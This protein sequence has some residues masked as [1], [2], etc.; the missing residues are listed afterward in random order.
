MILV[1]SQ[2]GGA[3]QLAQH[4]LRTD[5]NEHVEL[6]EIRGFVSEDVVGA[7]KEA[8]GIAKGTRCKQFLFSLSMNPPLDAD[9]GVD[10][11]ENALD[12]IEEANGL[13]GQP[14]VVIFHE[15]EGRRHCHAVWSRIDPETMTAKHLPYFKTKLQGIARELYLEH[16]WKMPR[17]FLNAHETDPR[18]FSL[19]EWQ[20]AKRM[21]LHGADLKEIIQDCW[22]VSDSRASF[23]AALKECGFLLAKG[24]RRDFVAV[25]LEGEVMSVARKTGKKAKEVRAKLG[26]PEG[27]PS[28]DEAKVQIANELTAV[29]RGYIDEVEQA[30]RQDLRPLAARRRAMAERHRNARQTLAESQRKRQAL[31]TQARLARLRKGVLGLWDCLTGRRRDTL[32]QNV[33]ELAKATRR[34][35]Q[36]R[37]DLTELQLIERRRLQSEF[38]KLR[39]HHLEIMAEVKRELAHLTAISGEPEES[40]Q[41]TFQHASQKPQIL[42]QTFK[43]ATNSQSAPQQTPQPQDSQAKP[44]RRPKPEIE[45]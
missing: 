15:K 30:A 5:E 6:H 8:Q 38:Q 29:V 27:L 19:A 43:R 45:M 44:T 24:D 10:V 41:Q 7:L 28:V 40:L 21:G 22:A 23:A 36:E 20:Q 34:D 39:A 3:K 14:R 26:E 18:N 32:R 35:Q 42:R 2:R 1:A 25:S 4:L 9:V 17:G 12:R 31:E 37:Q 16:D 13:N 11:F 33:E